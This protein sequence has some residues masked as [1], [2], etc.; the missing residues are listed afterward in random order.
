VAFLVLLFAFIAIIFGLA[1]LCLAL[2]RSL[3]GHWQPKHEVPQTLHGALLLIMLI[4]LPIIGLF[5][6]MLF[7]AAAMGA[8]I[9]KIFT[10]KVVIKLDKS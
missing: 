8:I 7:M 3:P 5:S 10:N 4:N 9:I 2:G 6:L 1:G